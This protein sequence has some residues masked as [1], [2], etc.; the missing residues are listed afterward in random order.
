MRLPFGIPPRGASQVDLVG[1]G[2]NSVDLVAVVSEFPASNTK[3]QLVQFER[4]PGGEVAT[5][6]VAC[7]RL[8]WT[9][10]YIGRFGSDDLG[11]LSRLHLE[12][13]GVGLAAAQ[14]VE[15][16]RNRFAVI[17]VDRRNG[18][19][20][21]LWDRDAALCM[22]PET[23]APESIVSARMLLVDTSDIEAAI[24][25]A[26]VARAGGI[27][28]MVDA[29]E[30]KPGL[31]RLF[32]EID[33]IIVAH[34]VPPALT[35]HRE[36]GRALAAMA[37]E[38]RAPVLCVTLGPEG[39]LTRCGGQEIRTPAFRVN[40]VDTTGAGDVFRGA[41][42]AAC[43]TSPDAELEHVLVYATAGAALSCR[44][45]GAQSGSPTDAEVR[46]LAGAGILPRGTAAQ[47]R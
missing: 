38:F 3:Q 22:Q 12:R 7:A 29:D 8:G 4:L 13:E 47:K 42:A 24:E 6:L 20:T 28:T 26:R 35:G 37:G 27:P 16:A 41:F 25:A 34:D 45:I 40:C 14:T 10:R 32:A 5:A 15:G 19:R 1:L 39:S 2:L 36:P 18:E 21:V 31:D 43:F 33:V 44:A 9:T 30:V 11:T 23:V 17:L 46:Q